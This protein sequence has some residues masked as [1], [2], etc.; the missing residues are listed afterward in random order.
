MRDGAEGWRLEKRVAAMRTFRSAPTPAWRMP[1]PSKGTASR[2]SNPESDPVPPT[3]PT[4]TS[5]PTLC[6]CR[7]ASSSA[8]AP[9]SEWPTTSAGL[10]TPAAS[11]SSSST[12][13]LAAMPI[14]PRRSDP[15]P[16]RSG[17][18]TRW[19]L[20]SMSANAAQSPPAPGW[21]CTSTTTG[22]FPAS[23]GAGKPP[24][25]VSAPVVL[26]A[27]DVLGRGPCSRRREGARRPAL[28]P[29]R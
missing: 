18:S 4:R 2:R 26:T 25:T 21:P 16:G 7:R 15:Q 29:T 10:V 3:D 1:F 5:A 6:G 28:P 13:A 20:Q 23:I 9:P 12:S 19:S 22:P 8:T 24:A 11:S 14:A 27:K 17:A